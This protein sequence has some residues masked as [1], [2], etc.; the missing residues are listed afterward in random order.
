MSRL[1]DLNARKTHCPQGHEYTPENTY[2]Q[3]KGSRACRTCMADT[4]IRSA[5]KKR[6]ERIAS[7]WVPGKRAARSWREWIEE[8]GT[9]CWLWTGALNDGGYARWPTKDGGSRQAH[10]R[11]YELLVGPIPTG[12]QIDHLCRVKRCVNPDHLEPVTQAENLARA[13]RLWG[14]TECGHGHPWTEENIL[15]DYD[16]HRRCR[17]CRREQRRLQQQRRRERALTSVRT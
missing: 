2:V 6:A 12:L 9:G 13:G 4:A 8:D 7:G 1:S 16:G 17:I 5:A 10:R 14:K 11:I 15:V 3:P